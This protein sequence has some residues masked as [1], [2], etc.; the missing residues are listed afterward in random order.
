M[1]TTATTLAAIVIVLVVAAAVA[2][3]VARHRRTQALRQRFGPE[4]DRTITEQPNRRKAERNLRHRE[5]RHDE[6]TLRELDPNQREQYAAEWQQTQAHFAEAPRA[7]T[8][9]ADELVTRVMVDRG[10]PVEDFDTRAEDLSVEHA[11]TIG[12]YREAHEISRYNE[13][14]LASTEQLRQ[15]LMH[16]RALF[17]ELLGDP[18]GG[19]RP[20]TGVG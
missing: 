3:A 17:A 15:A 14:G 13:R 20:A 2:T 8:R 9:E 1:S 6:L 7:A 12:H 4:Y 16:Y 10:Y 5:Q 18:R 19:G 11:Q